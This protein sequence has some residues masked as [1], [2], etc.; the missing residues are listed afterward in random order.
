M[1]FRVYG[2]RETVD[3]VN[4]YALGLGGAIPADHFVS[5][6]HSSV[7]HFAAWLRHIGVEFEIGEPDPVDIPRGHLVANHL[8][9]ATY[10]RPY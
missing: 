2:D 10:G 4:S 7:D 8:R 1:S 3:R 5:V 6:P 9:L